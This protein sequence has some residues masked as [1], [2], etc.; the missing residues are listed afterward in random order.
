MMPGRSFGQGDA[1]QGMPGRVAGQ[2]MPGR[3]AGQGDAGQGEQGRL[4]PGRDDAGQGV[5]PGRYRAG[6]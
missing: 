6:R 1:G 4:M 2:G 5:P 3:V